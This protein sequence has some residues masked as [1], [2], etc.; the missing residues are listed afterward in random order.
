[1]FF[2]Y[3]SETCGLLVEDFGSRNFAVISCYYKYRV[4][5]NQSLVGYLYNI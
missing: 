3:L 1:M 5:E 2:F 4:K